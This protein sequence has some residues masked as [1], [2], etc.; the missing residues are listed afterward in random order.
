MGTLP[1]GNLIE[2]CNIFR[3]KYQIFGSKFPVNHTRLSLVLSGFWTGSIFVQNIRFLQEISFWA[4]LFFGGNNY[5]FRSIFL[6]FLNFCLIWIMSLLKMSLQ[7][8]F[9]RKYHV[10]LRDFSQENLRF[11][12][13]RKLLRI[14][15]SIY[16]LPRINNFIL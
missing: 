1:A 11:F 10:D 13:S 5:S 7:N 2:I 15:F 16:Q 4:E 3:R 6:I 8:F 12:F 14:Q 9:R